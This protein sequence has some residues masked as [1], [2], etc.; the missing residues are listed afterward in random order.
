MRLGKAGEEKIGDRRDEQRH[1]RGKAKPADDDPAERDARL[2]A[3]ALRQHQGQTAD[4]GGYHRHH[5]R[6]QAD[7][8]GL[9]D[10]LAHALASIAQ[11]IGDLDRSEERRGGKE[12]VSTWSSR[13]SPVQ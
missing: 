5:H 12:W 1:R 9:L 4:D 8:A 11:L 6:T 10:R 13:W 3:R 2:S 7:A